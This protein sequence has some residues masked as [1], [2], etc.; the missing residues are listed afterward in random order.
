MERKEMREI[1]KEREKTQEKE[2]RRKQRR[3]RFG[4][5]AIGQESWMK[6]TNPKIDKCRE[7]T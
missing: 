2:W 6:Y 7:G 4:E 1:L 5:K 3:K